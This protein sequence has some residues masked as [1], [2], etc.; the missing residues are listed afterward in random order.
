MLQ[1]HSHRGRLGSL[2]REAE[3]SYTGDV[4][5]NAFIHKTLIQQPR[6]QDQTTSSGRDHAP[7]SRG[8]PQVQA[9]QERAHVGAPGTRD[10]ATMREHGAVLFATMHL[11]CGYVHGMTKEGE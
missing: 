6:L 7:Q 11:T 2:A 8:Y 9:A 3:E 4:A 1:A 5:L 10:G